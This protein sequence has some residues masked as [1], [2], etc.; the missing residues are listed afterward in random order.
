[1]PSKKRK[2]AAKK[3]KINP[4]QNA[5]V[6]V[7][8]KKNGSSVD[9]E[10]KKNGSFENKSKDDNAKEVNI[11]VGSKSNIHNR[12]S[13][14]SSNTSDDDSRVVEKNIV[15]VESAPTESVPIVETVPEKISP[16]VD[17][18]KPV[19]PLLQEVSQV[20]DE[21]KNDS[22]K[23]LVLEEQTVAV[24]ETSETNVSDECVTP[25]VVDDSVLK[26]NDVENASLVLNDYEISSTPAKNLISEVNGADETNTI[27][28]SNTQA[29][30]ASTAVAVQS[31]TSWKSCCGIFELF[32]GSESLIVDETDRIE[33]W[34]C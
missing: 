1:M 25:S 27:G 10:Q 33:P 23:D 8:Q 30:A 32:S 13:S 26:E 19:D 5:S 18:V 21:I 6:D 22:K 15:V 17:P 7:E 34:G 28:H 11:E 9:V 29:P 12:S 31:R 24:S 3:K 16:I 2:A 14:S 20:F 4:H